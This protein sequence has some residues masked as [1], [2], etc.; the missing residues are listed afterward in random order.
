MTNYKQDFHIHTYYSDGLDSPYDAVKW[1]YEGAKT[2]IA[3][4]DHDNV[5]GVSEAFLAA[6]EFGIKIHTGIEFSTEEKR[7]IGL[8]ILGYDI[9]ITNK[10]LLESCEYIKELRNK[11]ND[12]I[13]NLL[14]K[15]Y[16]IDYED[17][18]AMTPTGYIGKPVIAR[19]LVSKGFIKD[20]AEAFEKI[21]SREEFKKIKKEKIL[22]VEA[23]GII[24]GA[25]GKA[26]LAHPG[27]IRGIGAR[28]SQEFFNNFNILID[29]LIK[30]GIDGIECT[31]K[32][33]SE[34]ENETFHRIA[35]E[36]KLIATVG[37]DYHGKD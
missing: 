18:L 22:A 3:I 1:A 5:S 26:V 33:H 4:T 24:K 6:E 34:I 10:K 21:F 17:I 16:D 13:I 14:K 20:K 27:L 32:K 12:K 2:E 15:Y 11:R 35:K 8:H 31:Y 7:G 9:D 37:S 30:L 28:E 23:I 29:E 36:K 19:A 25:G